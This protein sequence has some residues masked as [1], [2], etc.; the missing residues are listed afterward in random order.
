MLKSMEEDTEAFYIENKET[1]L[2]NL[3]KIYS[4]DIDEETEELNKK[5]EEIASTI[6]DHTSI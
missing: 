5:F 3:R 4:F 1:T 2:S 6:Y